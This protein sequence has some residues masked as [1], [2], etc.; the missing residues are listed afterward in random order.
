VLNELCSHAI[1]SQPEECCGLVAGIDG[2][3]FR[4]V[5]RCRNNMTMLHRKDPDTYPRSGSEAYHMSEID[6]FAALQ[7]AK[8]IGEVVTAV[9]HSHVGA[10]AYF[11]ELDQEFAEHEL[12][13]FPGAAQIVMAVWDGRVAQVGLFERDPELE[14]LVGRRVEACSP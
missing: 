8:E 5:Y 6:Y 13:P 10:G 14:T 2:D 3:P 7:D 1:D 12:F 11:S 9:Y 4:T